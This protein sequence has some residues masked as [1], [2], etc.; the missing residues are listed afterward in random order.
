[1]RIPMFVALVIGFLAL[2]PELARA[3]L[4]S[5]AS[6][7]LECLPYLAASVVLAPLFGRFADAATAFAGCGCG[8]AP[9]ALS[10]PAA[11]ATAALFGPVV[12][13]ARFIAALVAWR[14]AVVEEH[15]HERSLLHELHRLAPSALT[16][17]V[18]VTALPSLHLTVVPVLVLFFCGALI[19]A[20][21]TPCTLGGIALASTFYSAAP[22]LS[23]GVLFT[24]GIITFRV[25]H[26]VDRV[27]RRVIACRSNAR[28]STH[29]D[30]T[31]RMFVTLRLPRIAL[32]IALVVAIVIGAPMPPASVN[33]TTLTD[34][35]PGERLSF[36]GMYVDGTLM[37]YAIT[38]CRADA[39][40]VSIRLLNRL[41]VPN[42]IWVRADGVIARSGAC[43]VLSASKIATI[44]PP[45]DP[46]L[47]R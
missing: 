26:V 20:L 30:S 7:L 23:Y 4:A 24:S 12:A 27:R 16:C 36:T 2:A 22:A 42:R 34:L 38:C 19:G 28:A 39:A 45:S 21:A 17:G 11:L 8:N 6:V 31:R 25:H 32:P 18:V 47:Y 41:R 37:R 15:V 46:F 40:P 3:I 44:A 10:L 1:M 14:I 43:L 5:S 9:G 35:Y 33:E 13:I 29:D